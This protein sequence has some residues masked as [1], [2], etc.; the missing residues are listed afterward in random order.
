MLEADA[1]GAALPAV[2]CGVFWPC[3]VDAQGGPAPAACCGHRCADPDVHLLTGVGA[4]GVRCT[5]AD[6][7]LLAARRKQIDLAQAAHAASGP[8]QA[9]RWERW[10]GG[11][12]GDLAMITTGTG[13]LRR[14]EAARLARGFRVYWGGWAARARA[15]EREGGGV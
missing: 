5:S 13:Q 8:A 12:Y 14:G 6:P 9:A 4:D 3:V 11:S 1:A 15:G 7:A 2:L 10:R